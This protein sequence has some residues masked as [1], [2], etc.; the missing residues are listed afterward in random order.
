[1]KT[2]FVLVLALA[3]WGCK[4]SSNDPPPPAQPVLRSTSAVLPSTITV[5]RPEQLPATLPAQFV[6]VGKPGE[7]K[8]NLV[9]LPSGELLLALFRG[10]VSAEGYTESP[11]LYRSLDGGKTWDN[12]TVLPYAGRE[13]YFTLTSKGVL[14]LTVQ[15]MPKDHRNTTGHS[16][17]AV[18]RSTDWGYTWSA[19]YVTAADVPGGSPSWG[20]FVSRTIHE[21]S[22]GDLLMGVSNAWANYLWRSKDQ[23]VTWV[24]KTPVHAPRVAYHDGHMFFDELVFY[25]PLDDPNTLLAFGRV[26]A[27]TLTPAFAG[28]TC[29]PLAGYVDTSD[30]MVLYRSG[31]GGITWGLVHALGDAYG[32]MY[33]SLTTLQDG[34]MLF[35]FTQRS[36]SPNSVEVC[37]DKIGVEVAPAEL[38]RFGVGSRVDGVGFTVDFAQ[39]RVHVMPPIPSN[40]PLSGGFGNTIQTYDGTLVTAYSYRAADGT[41]RSQVTR[42]SLPERT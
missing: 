8:P 6:P 33:P 5:S 11:M 4:G 23:G 28:T 12:G 13:P 21:R 29:P 16:T 1:M 31:D 18:L 3:L 26:M 42:W 36:C 10:D 19:T 15:I 2:V 14:F 35:T 27:C 22:S 17:A 38:T 20:T 32:Q 34:R 30:V 7:Y 24:E 39:D 25:Q 37:G 40:Y 9:Q 41:L